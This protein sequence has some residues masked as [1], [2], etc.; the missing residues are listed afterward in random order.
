MET[1][2]LIRNKGIMKIGLIATRFNV[3]VSYLRTKFIF[4][5]QSIESEVIP[6]I[7]KTDSTVQ[8]KN[9]DLFTQVLLS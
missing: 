5:F 7:I 2:S 6:R 8:S 9:G 4:L 3:P 1:L